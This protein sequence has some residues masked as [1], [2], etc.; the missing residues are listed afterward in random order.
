MCGLLIF[1]R[2]PKTDGRVR[3][4]ELERVRVTAAGEGGAGP[5]RSG[6]RRWP[7]LTGA[8]KGMILRPK[9]C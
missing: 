9:V 4:R 5:R 1:G 8:R 3:N 6:L 7:A 2:V